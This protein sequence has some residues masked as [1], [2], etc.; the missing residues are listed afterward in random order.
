MD[1]IEGLNE[2]ITNKIK[3][4][5]KNIRIGDTHLL[6]NLIIKI[7]IFTEEQLP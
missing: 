4:A 6:Y 1:P 3:R 2:K 7:L 5:L